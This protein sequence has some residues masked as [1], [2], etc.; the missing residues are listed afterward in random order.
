MY[1]GEIKG[2]GPRYCPSIEDKV[3]RF[4]ARTG[5]QI[6]IEPEGRY[7]PEVYVNGMSTSMPVDVQ[8]DVLHTVPGME[9]AILARP[10]YAVEYDYFPPDQIGRTLE[11]NEVNGLYFAGQVNGTSGYEE[12]AAQGFMAGINAVLS[13]SCEKPLILGRD[14][15]YIGVLIDDLTTK[16][17]DEPYRMF[18]SRAEFRLLLRQDNALDRL[19]HHG[20]ALGLVP[21]KAL[22]AVERKSNETKNLVEALE[23]CVFPSIIGNELFASMGLDPV[24]KP[25]TMAQVLKRPQVHME[26]IV[27][28]L[29]N[30]SRVD[31]GVAAAVEYKIK[32][33]G[34]IEKQDR[35]I[36]QMRGLE[37][38]V[39]P[40]NFP[41]AD[42]P[43]LSTEARL[44]LSAKKPET[45]GQ[46]SR[47]AG[48]RAADLSILAV[49][50]EKLSA[51]RQSPGKQNAQKNIG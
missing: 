12:A 22:E 34:Y 18:T 11:S 13:F 31:R 28:L 23:K 40:T 5:H 3:V 46:A 47:I 19:M 42:I 51:S 30:M 49:H 9:D 29:N 10:G 16:E 36:N 48:V 15:A 37:R 7:H 43:G 2:I 44:K 20:A 41:Y 1:S 8:I 35:Q 38:R 24:D 26:H 50:I 21:G 4:A 33:S 39:L 45:M 32:Y 6:F 17:I 27:K 14:E 25:S